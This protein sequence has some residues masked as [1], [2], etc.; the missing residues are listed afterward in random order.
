MAEKEIMTLKKELSDLSK[1]HNQLKTKLKQTSDRG[2]QKAI[3]DQA[4]EI[5]KRHRQ[6]KREK[7]NAEEIMKEFKF[8]KGI[9]SVEAFRMAVQTCAFWGDTWAISTLERVLNIKLVLFSSEAYH[10]EDIDNVLQCGQLNDRILE[11]KGEFKPEYYILCNYLGEHYELITYKTKTAFNFEELPIDIKKLIVNKCMEG[12]AGPYNL[13]PEMN[14]FMTEQGKSPKQE[15]VIEAPHEELYNPENVFQFYSKSRDLK[16]GK[17]AGEKISEKDKGKFADLE[18]IKDWRKKLSNFWSAPFMLHGKRWDSV[19]H[20]YQGSKYKK[21]NPQVYD[22]FSL[23]SGSELS[24]NAA[25]AKGAGGKSGSFKKVR[26]IPKDVKID[27]DFFRG[28]SEKEMK[29]AQ[30]A[31]FTQNDEMKQLLKDTKDA[32]LQHF[33]RGSPPI[34]FTDLMKIRKELR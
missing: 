7:K 2:L 23:D 4:A 29:D 16:P 5:V 18:D 17:G 11:D 20:Y 31:K 19:E 33:S 25:M 13:I 14:K 32:K 24:K 15:P 6:A 22:E 26:I 1:D 3:V 12:N 28:R 30:Y 21:N 8:M 27:P 10:A 34:V 9:T